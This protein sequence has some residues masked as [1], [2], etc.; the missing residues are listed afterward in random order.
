MMIEDETFGDRT[1]QQ[2]PDDSM[3]TLAVLAARW[4]VRNAVAIRGDKTRPE[5]TTCLDI[6]ANLAS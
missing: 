1:D 3:C 6:E 5:P 4:P 2:L